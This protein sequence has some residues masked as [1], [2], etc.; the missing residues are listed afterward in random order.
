M[1]AREERTAKFIWR[2]CNARL[3][4]MQDYRD[5]MTWIEATV[6]GGSIL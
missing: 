6:L 2:W 4:M 1:T 5:C 3:G